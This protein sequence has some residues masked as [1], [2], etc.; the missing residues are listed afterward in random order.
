MYNYLDLNK[1]S[2]ALKLNEIGNNEKLAIQLSWAGNSNSGLS[3][4]YQQVDTKHNV[5]GFNLLKEF[6][7]TDEE[8]KYIKNFNSA[9]SKTKFEEFKKTNH[10]NSINKKIESNKNKL[11][12]L[13]DESIIQYFEYLKRIGV[14]NYKYENANCLVHLMDYH[15]QFDLSVNGKMHKWLQNQKNISLDLIKKFKLEETAWGRSEQGKKDVIRRFE[16]IESL[17]DYKVSIDKKLLL[18]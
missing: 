15:N 10:Y 3:F 12:D 1:A 8:I 18:I 2:T 7:C 13:F 11:K 9:P 5:N 14:F 16:N 4:G 6:G 17:G